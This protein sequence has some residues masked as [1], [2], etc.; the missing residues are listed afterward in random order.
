ML[1]VT[2]QLL[3]TT[4]IKNKNQL[5]KAEISQSHYEALARVNELLKQICVMGC[6]EYKMVM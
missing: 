4:C 2:G 6:Q 5:E 1:H 3:Q